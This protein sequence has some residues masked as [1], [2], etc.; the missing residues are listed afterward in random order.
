MKCLLDVGD[1]I[2]T[3]HMNFVAS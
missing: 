1:N 3:F 2:E